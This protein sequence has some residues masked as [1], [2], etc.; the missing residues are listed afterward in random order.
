MES[1]LFRAVKFRSL[2]YIGLSFLLVL[3][4]STFLSA[5][6]AGSNA[7]QLWKDSRAAFGTGDYA[8]AATKL[9]TIIKTSAASTHWLDN[10]PNLPP[11]PPKQ[12][13]L[14]PVFFMLSAAHFNAKDWP[15]AISTLEKYQQLFP[16]S[17]RFTQTTFSLA[18]AD[19]FGGHPEDAVPLFTSLLPIPRYHAKAFLLL[20]ESNKRLQKIPEAI[21]LLEKET[22]TPDLNPDYL[23]RVRM[24]LMAFY[25]NSKANDKAVALLKEVN[26]DMIHV[27]DVTQF[28]DAAIKLGDWYLANKNIVDAMDCYRRVYDNGQVL[29]LEQQQI[30]NLQHQRV[31]NMTLIQADPLNSDALQSENKDI[32]IQV[33]KDQAILASYKTLPP[34]PPPLLLRIAKAYFEDKRLWEAAVVYR[35]LMRRYPQC[36]DAESALYGSIV[37]FDRLKQTDRAEA[38]C[39]SYLTGYPQGKY[40]KSVGYIR[41]AL[42]YDAED[43]DKAVS[44]FQEALQNQPDKGQRQQ[45][46]LILGDVKLR[47][48][49][50][51]GA[52]A[53]YAKYLADFPAGS[54]VEQAQYRSALALFFGGKLDDAETAINAYLHKYPVGLYEADAA[55]R[56]ATI[57][58][59]RKDYPAAISQC[60][61]WLKKFGNDAPL[62]EVLSL[63]G[64]CYALEDKDDPAIQAYTRSYKAAQTTEVLNYSLFAAAK[65]LQKQAKWTDI[66]AMF[67]EF[68]DKNPDHPTVVDAVSWIGR[69]DIKLGKID[70]AKQF[71]ADT[72]KKYLD[73]P[74][75]EA[76]DEIIT[77]LAQLYGRRHGISVPPPAVAPATGGIP[78]APA[79]SALASSAAPAASATATTDPAAST[80]PPAETEPDPEKELADSLT[81]PDLDSKPTARARIL[82]AKSELGRIRHK[83]DVENQNLLDIAKDV[84]PEDLSATLLGRVGDCLVLNGR[85][86]EADPFYHELI[87]DYG[88]SAV[89]DFGYA[90]LGGN[91]LAKGDYKTADSYYAKALD[92]G[93]ASSKLKEITLGE[94]QALLAL[95]RPTEAKPYFEQVA[96][97]RA[98]RGEATAIS[99]LSLGEIQMRLGKLAEANAFYQRVYVAYQKYPATQAKAYLESGEVLAKL[100]KITEA[101]NT[102]DEMLKNPRRQRPGKTWP[103]WRRNENADDLPPCP[104]RGH[105]RRLR[106]DHYPEER[107]R[108]GGQRP[109]A[110]ERHDHDDRQDAQRRRGPARLLCHG[111]R[112]AEHSRAGHHGGG[113]GRRDQGRL[114]PRDGRDSTHCRRTEDPARC[115]RQLV[116]PG[117]ASR[118]LHASRPQA[119]RRRPRACHRDNRQFA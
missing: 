112:Q 71:M 67:H 36:A 86:A 42:A 23:G 115:S 109:G 10:V 41:G 22:A 57:Q 13:W 2:R 114:Q 18:Q 119:K 66:A 105:G 94:A 117:G 34:I 77:Q 89:V 106:P 44:Y 83:P 60:E 74:S 19:L 64:D 9:E 113:L 12:Q 63:E 6:D 37:V 7:G 39:Q 30:E 15:N 8:T 33:V 27:P 99:V 53:A 73:D 4:A 107:Q 32:D 20:V 21:A 31:T 104:A 70:E 116:G 72:A 54:Y 28:N 85:P 38:L 43:Y 55:Y 108:R 29:A 16:K 81:V 56:L 92:K 52:R 58:F 82:F 11:A 17:P 79:S 80:T 3:S 111:H 97:N 68:I 50:F 25:L 51:D 88:D 90:G 110:A 84:K 69:A 59:A 24:T 102:Y 76:V 46:E 5:Q 75:R 61:A 1:S 87:D 98:W 78:A 40:I 91:A 26:A 49:D 62:A 35:E 118:G 103:N 65:L 14:E 101:R 95:N 45:I 100:G 48:Q 93:L 47:K 96:S